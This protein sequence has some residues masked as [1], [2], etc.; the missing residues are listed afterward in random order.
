MKLLEFL[1]QAAIRA[2]QLVISP[3]L[4]PSCRFHPHC[5]AYASE[6]IETHGPLRGSWLAVKRVGRCHPFAAG[7][8]DPVP[9]S[10]GAPARGRVHG[11]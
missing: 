4:G 1:L 3:S 5:S 6:A 9:A 11:P 8:Y 7:G 2:Y 10:P